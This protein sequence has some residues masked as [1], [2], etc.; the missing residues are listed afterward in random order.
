MQRQRPPVARAHTKRDRGR[1]KRETRAENAPP[2]H[3]LPAMKP[4][5]GQVFNRTE[6]V[7]SAIARKATQSAGKQGKARTSRARSMYPVRI[8]ARTNA[9]ARSESSVTRDSQT[10][11]RW[12]SRSASP[13]YPYA[14]AKSAAR[15]RPARLHKMR[16]VRVCEHMSGV[17]YAKRTMNVYLSCYL[18]CNMRVHR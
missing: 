11:W 12:S 1:T 6:A 4:T 13:T 17:S 5:S 9:A 14:S 18:E 2:E 3:K 7:G 16:R 8:H 15:A 10:C